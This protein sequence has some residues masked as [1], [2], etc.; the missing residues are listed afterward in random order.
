MAGTFLIF[1]YGVPRQI[2]TGGINFISLSGDQKYDTNEIERIKHYK[3]LGYT[4]IWLLFSA[5]LLQLV[6]LLLGN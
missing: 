1:R 6:A 2:D 5:F 4:G 3:R